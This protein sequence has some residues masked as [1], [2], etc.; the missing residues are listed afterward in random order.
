MGHRIPQYQKIY[1]RLGGE[2][3]GMVLVAW[4]ERVY[5]LHD[6]FA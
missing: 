4:A 2:K 5:W 3:D 1:F 6:G